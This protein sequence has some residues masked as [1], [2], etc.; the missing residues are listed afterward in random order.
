MV[1]YPYTKTPVNLTKLGLEIEA[2]ETIITVLQYIN[3]SS[4]DLS[5]FFDGTLITEEET[6]LDTIV[7]NHDGQPPMTYTHYCRHCTNH[8][9]AQTLVEP[10]TCKCCGSPDIIDMNDILTNG[11]RPVPHITK[12]LEV[13]I[14]RIDSYTETGSNDEPY[15]TI[16]AAIDAASSGT[17]LDIIPGTYPEDITLKPG[18][19]LRSKLGLQPGVM[20]TGKV[21]WPS[22]AGTILMSGIYV[23]NDSDHA[24]DFGGTGVQKLRAYNS[25]FE[26]NSEGAHHGINHSNTN[27]GSEIFLKDSLIQVRDSSGGAKAIETVI[28]SQ[29]SIGLDN[30][31]VRLIDD[32]DNIAVN[33]KGAITYWQRMDEIRGR[34]IVSDLASCNIT[35][36]GMYANT[37]SCLETNSAGLSLLSTVI[38]SSTASPIVTGAGA[39]AFSQIGYASSGQGLAATL[40]GGLGAAIGAIPA[41]SADGIIYDPTISGLTATRVKTA[42]DELE[43][44]KEPADAA[45]MKE[46]ENVGLLT[47][48]SDFQSGTQV[49]ADI[50]THKNIVAAH[51]AKY[52][53]TEAVTAMGAKADGNSLNHDKYTLPANVMI[54]GENVSLLNNDS[55]FISDVEGTTVKSTGEVGDTKVLTEN[56][57]GGAAWVAPTV[58]KTHSPWILDV[59]GTSGVFYP[60]NA[61]GYCHIG[62]GGAITSTEALAQIRMPK[63][64][65]KAI[66][67]Y[68]LGGSGTFTVR[69]NGVATT[70]TGLVN[71]VGQFHL[72][73]TG[74]IEIA[75]GDL[76]SLYYDSG[77]NWTIYGIQIKYETE[78]I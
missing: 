41:E 2:D 71:S 19:Y 70:I 14:N 34:V 68:C 62:Q 52:L 8:C 27:I 21:S 10:T 39:F 49:D 58:G 25:K 1:E 45:I 42:L 72:T 31:T 22:G 12:V 29:G 51:H 3:Y 76:L 69:K 32:I 54:E 9:I 57:V 47:N 50:L 13:D 28:T 15:K 63:G 38:L 5:I 53:D 11:I 67:G 36:D 77:V 6:A 44:T 16:Q 74:A 75:E 26:T 56:G 43:S 64:R 33:L 46:G 66:Q 48:D 40:N 73:G 4:P 35:L 23:F 18:V 20:I 17:L 65:V 78:L 30:T 24:I 59:Y 60:N 37:L 61:T 7:M 55:G